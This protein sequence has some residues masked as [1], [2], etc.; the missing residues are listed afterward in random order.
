MIPNVPLTPDVGSPL[1]RAMFG[2]QDALERAC[3]QGGY[4]GWSL[5]SLDDLPRLRRAAVQCRQNAPDREYN[6]HL[7]VSVLA[8]AMEDAL[9]ALRYHDA[10]S[11]AR[12]MQGIPEWMLTEGAPRHG[13]TMLAGND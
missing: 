7:R 5:T 3:A 8:R 4:T 2:A 13:V 6:T 9:R 11:A 12:A 10:D 1:S